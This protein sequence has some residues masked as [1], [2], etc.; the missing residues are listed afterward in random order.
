MKKVR[1]VSV[2]DIAPYEFEK[3]PLWEANWGILVD[4]MFL[5]SHLCETK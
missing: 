5:V 4:L 2:A 1:I 3:S